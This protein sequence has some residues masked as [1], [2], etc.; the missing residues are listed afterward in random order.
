M[1]MRTLEHLAVRDGDTFTVIRR[2]SQE[3]LAAYDAAAARLWRHLGDQ[4][5]FE[6]V[7][8]NY[9]EFESILADR[10]QPVPAG[11]AVADLEAVELSVNRG[12]MNYLSMIRTFLDHTT[13]VLKRHYRDDPGRIQAFRE[14]CREAFDAHFAYRFVSKLRNFAQH[15]GLPVQQ[16][17][18]LG[19]LVDPVSRTRT[20]QLRAFC[21]RDELLREFDWGPVRG[22]LE[23]QGP[24]FDIGPLLKGTL[25]CLEAINAGLV[26]AE[27]AELRASARTIRK[28]LGATYG[29]AG[30]PSLVPSVDRAALGS[31]WQDLF[32]LEQVA[33][34]LSANDTR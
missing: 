10:E 4:R 24:V 29:Q 33:A 15:I 28:L 23:Q 14:A 27:T 1:R 8:L 12:V 18:A 20:V 26:E 31:V 9:R 17:A 6:L 25:N 2:L 7:R 11:D 34:L 13:A 16:V 30:T 32:D 5:L 3:E 19:V 21:E 22:G